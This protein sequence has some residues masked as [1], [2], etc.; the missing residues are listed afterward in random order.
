MEI[1]EKIRRKKE[2]QGGCWKSK[3][4]FPPCPHYKKNNRSQIFFG[5]GQELNVSLATLGLMET[6]CKN[7]A[8]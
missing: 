2:N 6:V 5:S 8:N 3:S 4:K 7:K 1:K